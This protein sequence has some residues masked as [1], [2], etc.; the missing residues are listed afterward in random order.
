VWFD[1]VEADVRKAAFLREVAA[2]TGASVGIH[3]IRIENAE[4]PSAELVTARA[5]APL[6]KLLPLLA[7]FLSSGGVALLPKGVG[8]DE[9]LTAAQAHWHMKAERHASVTDPFGV[10]LRLTEVHRA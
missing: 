2:A 4:M 5:L 7:P 1:L 6:P 8:V 9:E 10:I 3:A